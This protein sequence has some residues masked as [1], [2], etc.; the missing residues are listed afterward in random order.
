MQ[1]SSS[2]S[3][4]TRSFYPFQQCDLVPRLRQNR[5]VRA[6]PRD[7]LEQQPR[8]LRAGVSLR[9]IH[10]LPNRQQSVQLV[11]PSCAPFNALGFLAGGKNAPGLVAEALC[12]HSSLPEPVLPR[13][14]A[15]TTH[16]RATV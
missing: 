7:G 3:H 10:T 2:C 15:L 5:A 6:R 16:L 1:S 12:C 14:T 11:S 4:S 8:A 13:V 9:F